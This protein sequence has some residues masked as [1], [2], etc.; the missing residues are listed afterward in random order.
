M[1]NMPKIAPCRMFEIKFTWGR[2]VC[3]CVGCCYDGCYGGCSW[4]CA[5][6]CG[7]SSGRSGCGCS[8]GCCWFCAGGCGSSGGWTSI[9]IAFTVS[10]NDEEN[11]VSFYSA[12]L[13]G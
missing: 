10:C 5:V 3:G 12:V 13:V 2:R 6:G 9:E 11:V 8:G 7:C 4:F 1:S